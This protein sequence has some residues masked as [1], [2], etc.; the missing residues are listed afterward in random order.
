MTREADQ[1]ILDLLQQMESREASDLFLCEGKIPAMRV[2]GTVVELEEAAT[3]RE[4]IQGLV[5]RVVVG[6][7]RAA[8]EMRGD[9][10]AGLT[11]G[12]RRYRLNLSK[13]QGKLNVVA[14][15]VPS[16]AMELAS[17]GL[18]DVIGKMVDEGRGL[19]L[20]TGA[21]G[22]GKSTTLAAMVH[23]INTRR[24]AHVITVE[25]PI[26]YVHQDVQA[27]ISQ[28]E[29]GGD[30]E[31][32]QT[33]LKH[34]VRQSPDVILIGEMR[35]A[36]TMRVALSA[37]LT[38]HMVMASLHTIDATQTLQRMLSY[39]PAHQRDQIALDLSL[40]LS[41]IVSQRL[42]PRQD[43]HA[44][45]LATEIL[46]CTNA[47]GRLLREQRV[48]EIDDLMR[49]LRATDM[50]SFNDSLLRLYRE[51]EIDFQTGQAYST[52]PDEFSLLAKGMATG[53]DSFR[54]VGGPGLDTGLDMKA[55]LAM[56]LERKAS[57]LHLTVGRPP[58]F[59]ITGQLKPVGDQSLSESDMRMLLYSIMSGRQRT[60]YELEREVDFALALEDGERFRV[61]AYFQKGRMAAALRAIPSQV[62]QAEVLGLPSE[63]LKLG[64]KPQGLLLVV[65]P[66]GA[67]KSTTMA[68]LIDRI[69]RSRRCRI[70]TI[71]DPVEYSHTSINATVDQ[72]EV[73]QDTKSFSAAL[74]FILRQDPDVILVGEMRDL[75]TISSVLTAAETG[76]LVL[77]T[78]HSNDCVQAI[79][80][81][82]D[83]YPS[84]Q[85]SQARAQLS[86]SL[87]GV[88]SQ[89]L[90]PRADGSGRIG[91]FEI[92]VATPAIR[93]LIRE[94]KMHQALGTMESSRRD[95][96]VTMDYALKCLVEDG[97]VTR[98]TALQ[99]ALSTNSI[100]EGPKS[101]PT[102]RVTPGALQSNGG[103]HQVAGT[104][105]ESRPKPVGGSPADPS[106]KKFPWSR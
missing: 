79:D 94:N 81:V 85:Q 1:N 5:D 8:F 4:E 16:G 65:G 100:P 25:D 39:F 87:L 82:I 44:R 75:E 53:S 90:L 96:M 70:I 50:C 67:G 101:K 15:A 27:R 58:I 17:L 14:R 72:R 35:D 29:I 68:C 69:N 46:R 22:S 6:A 41:G 49:T 40:C 76:H 33:A 11:L 24:A 102:P 61:N 83:V 28:R 89:R 73:Y 98:E 34:V 93:N 37:A 9:W 77:A 78:M 95:G 31:S 59:R 56:V 63:V 36:E 13:Q 62:P 91:A 47:V 80:R 84:H 74:K 42:V 103:G 2:H 32:F 23:H 18:P 3:G 105:S 45:V 54:G 48:D 20:V 71:E 97:H 26:E 88:V 43:G 66:T 12:D 10:D 104:V 64:D 106:K 19:I 92:M 57:D 55:L 60:V 30:T 99:H 21:T 86:S 52:N 38:G 51:G 7:S